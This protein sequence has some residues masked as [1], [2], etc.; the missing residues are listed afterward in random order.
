MTRGSHFRSPA[1]RQFLRRVFS[2]SL[3][4]LFLCFIA[5][6]FVSLRADDSANRHDLAREQ[7]ARAENLREG[8]EAKPDRQ[9]SLQ[10][11]A[12]VVSAYHRVYLITPSAPEVPQAMKQ[13][14]DLYTVMGQRFDRRYFSDALKTYQSLQKEYPVNRDREATALAIADIQRNRLAQPAL[15]RQAYE[16]FIQQYPRS[17][18]VADARRALA[19]MKA[20]AQLSAD[21]ATPPSAPAPATNAPVD[22]PVPVSAPS[23]AIT[24]T[25]PAVT[26][27]S[28]DQS[29]SPPDG[30]N[31]GHIRVWNANSYTRIVIDLGSEAKYQAVRISNPDRIYFDID[32]AKLSRELLHTPIEVPSG[33]YLKTV[34][35]AQNRPDVVRIVL[36]VAQVKDYSVFELANPDRL[37][38]DVYGPNAK[39]ELAHA[40]S[41]NSAVPTTTT[42]PAAA[43]SLNADD[44]DSSAPLS[45]SKNAPRRDPFSND[46][47]AKPAAN[48]ARSAEAANRAASTSAKDGAAAKETVSAKENTSVKDT[49]A[50]LGPASIPEPTLAGE[51][52]LTRALGLKTSR[53][54][55]DAGHGGH[56]TGTIGPSGLMEKDLS[57]DVARR[58]GK[59]ILDRVPSADVIYTRDDD[60]YVSLEKR[61]AIANAEKADL[62]LSIHA[63]SSD[64]HSVTGV[65][66]YY[67]N[68]NA[69]TSALAVAARENALAQGSVHDLQDLVKK[70]ADNE[71]IEESRDLAA[72][73][74]DSLSMHMPNQS[75]RDRGVRK[76]PFVVLIGANMP[77]VLAEVSFLSNP[78][79][80]QWLKKPDNRQ[81][82]SEGLFQGVES[83]L[84]STNSLA[85]NLTSAEPSPRSTAVAHAANP[86]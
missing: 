77:S 44:N 83:Y 31:L 57:L 66:T 63:N 53:I 76:A 4:S 73:I 72:K 16:D 41:P 19:E 62:F 10:D 22:T 65:E 80:E 84:H 67:L 35:V 39:T 20:D 8:L 74:Q 46:G 30:S 69:S 47:N 7:F 28:D 82:I 78:E 9:R 36:E 86:Q 11:Y 64:D 58:L 71:K 24:Q 14:G 70:I 42:S 68:F 56:D 52:S 38:V 34:R 3:F 61:T 17:Q 25:K 55:I 75:K 33:G 85:S 59:L 49:I 48:S 1:V 81:Q 54:V 2:V 13:V 40:K 18:H 43:S 79:D 50:E 6:P 15:A 12:T 27:A 37:V 29:D 51:H 32:N 45:A 5:A 26:P 60:S 23:A 21:A